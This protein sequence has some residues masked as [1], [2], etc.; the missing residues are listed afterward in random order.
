MSALAQSNPDYSGSWGYEVKN[1]PYGNFYGTIFLIKA[2]STY[3]G[4]VVNRA[5]KQYKLEVLRLKGNRLVFTSDVEETNSVFT[6]NFKG[7]SLLA[8]VEVKG[9]NFLY[10]LK[11]R[12]KNSK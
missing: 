5:G 8:T 2:G 3:K 12:K 11:A 6:C 4:N 7:D 10:K 9:D 1:T